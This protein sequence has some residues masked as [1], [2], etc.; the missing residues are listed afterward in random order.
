M[1]SGT[2]SDNTGLSGVSVVE[3]AIQVD[4]GTWYSRGTG[5][6]NQGSETFFNATSTNSFTTW[7]SSGFPFVSGHDYYIKSRATDRA[8][9]EEENFVVSVNTITVTVDSDQPSSRVTF[10]DGLEVRSA[11]SQV[12]GTAADGKSGVD[13]VYVSIGQLLGLTTSYFDGAGFNAATEYFNLTNWSGSNPWTYNTAVPYI[14]GLKYMFR[15]YAV[16]QSGNIESALPAQIEVYYDVTKPTTSISSPIHASYR[17][18]VP[19]IIGNAYD[20][21]AEVEDLVSSGVQVRVLEVGGQWWGGA[22]FNQSN[23]N[24]AWRNALVG[25]TTNW[26]YDDVLISNQLVSGTTYLIQVRATDKAVPPNQGPSSDGTDS[27]FSIGVDSITIVVDKVSPVSSIFLPPEMTTSYYNV[28]PVISGTSFDGISGITAKSQ[29]QLSIEELL[30]A[31]QFWSGGSTFTSSTEQF[32]EATSL[33]A[34]NSTWTLNTPDFTHGYTYRIRVQATDNVDPSGNFEPLVGLS[35]S[36]FVYDIQYPTATVTYPVNTG[37]I[38]QLT[39]VTGSTTEEFSVTEVRVTMMDNTT[40]LWW[41]QS[42]TTFSLTGG[43]KIFYQATPNG[44]G[45]WST[46]EWSFDENELITGRGYSIQIYAVDAAGNQQPNAT[47]VFTWDTTDPISFV[48]S[49]ADNSFV[50]FGNLTIITGT[51]DDTNNI[52]TTEVSIQRVS[53]GFFWNSTL[54][55]FQNTGGTPIYLDTPAALLAPLHILP[56]TW[57]QTADLPPDVRLTNGE[58]YRVQA[59]AT[60]VP[61]NVQQIID[62]GIVFTYDVQAPTVDIQYP[63]DSVLYP[64]VTILSGTAQDN[65]NTA[66][67]QLRLRNT[68]SNEYWNEALN[69]GLGDW[70]G[71]VVWNVMNG[72][73]PT[74]S[75]VDWDFSVLPNPWANQTYE[76]NVRAQDEAGNYTTVYSTIQFTIDNVAP[77]TYST[78]PVSGSTYN[79]VSAIHG[80]A[81]DGTAPRDISEVRVKIWRIIGG[82]TTYWDAGNWDTPVQWNLVSNLNKQVGSLYN[83]DYTHVN[84]TQQAP[85]PHAWDSGTTYYFMS[86]AIDTAGNIGFESSTKTFN[87]DDLPPES[88]VTLAAADQAYHSSDLTVLSG[89]AVDVTS[90]L[91]SV[92]FW[93]KDEDAPGGQKWF[94]GGGFNNPTTYYLDATQVFQTSWT[95]TSGAL[96]SEF[97]S[98]DSHHYVIQSSASDVIGN[99]ETPTVEN[100]F[101]ID[102]TNPTSDIDAP[103]NGLTYEPNQPIFG[104]AADPGYTTGIDGTGSG[105]VDTLPWHQ[106]EVELLIL[107]DEPTLN[108][109]GP[110]SYPNFSGNDYFWNGSTWVATG[111]GETWVAVDSIDAGGNWTYSGIV[112]SSGWIKGKTYNVWVR[113]TDNAGNV[114]TGI[115]PGPQFQIADPAASFV[116]TGLVSGQAAGFDQTVTVEAVDSEGFRAT[117]Y[118]GTV[119]FS[120]ANGFEISDTNAV[121][122]DVHGLPEDY[123]FDLSDGGIFTFTNAVRFRRAGNRE[124]RVN[125][126][127]Q[128]ISGIQSNVNVIAASAERLLVVPDGQTHAPGE[129]PFVDGGDGHTGN[130][131]SK[132][133]GNSNLTEILV[134]DKYWN[135]VASSEPVVTI[136]TTDPYDTEPGTVTLSGGTRTVNI[137][138][139][140]A[141]NQTITASGAGLPN[142]SDTITVDPDS[143]DRL[144]T[145]LP[146]ESRVQGKYNVTPFGKSGTVGYI[147]AGFEY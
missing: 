84:F 23:P 37:V 116:V 126:T 125:D 76:M 69:G 21:T 112:V 104:T 55:D 36:V 102:K 91:S 82:A 14:S 146:G 8:N 131:N 65:N 117:A 81:Q 93:I 11:I 101:L 31:G 64:N 142:T 60:D 7:F 108:A 145:V 111:G 121:L 141:G 24:S 86:R 33:L 115:Q 2:V 35:S 63:V 105:V 77:V 66:E 135:T 54:N 70:G 71:P 127:I 88:R 72:S 30:P 68:S 67:V 19:Q 4:T 27:N 89:T 39:A 119:T 50:G 20:Q 96:S 6:F 138:M 18:A 41:N 43:G 79:Y 134:V 92:R 48:S 62:A 29:V 136:T 122:D 59:R 100:R 107:R 120:V 9:N 10:P 58:Q 26:T 114:Q 75:Q 109:A 87:F 110:V 56:R 61:G 78:F 17:S 140:T 129:S 49:P 32:Y 12:T 124:I 128:P 51:A 45:D 1:I 53:D 73:S 22:T 47:S 139:T 94:D 3:L 38:S 25:S 97:S 40:G 137:I 80:T 83:W 130:T 16:D 147:A 34:A 42:T 90:P 57:E 143:A 106:G 123:Y 98:G 113:A 103:V 99:S 85:L 13:Q 15:S 52:Q 74:N 133:A 28:L 144:V 44:P 95:Y 5:M 132:V 118:Q 46:W